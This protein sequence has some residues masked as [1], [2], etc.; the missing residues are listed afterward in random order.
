MLSYSGCRVLSRAA[1][2]IHPY[3]PYV[4][5]DVQADAVVFR[6]RAGMRLGALRAAVGRGA[7]GQH[8]VM[9]SCRCIAAVLSSQTN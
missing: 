7:A 9:R 5:L 2:P 8:R 4:R 1:A 3:F 6:P